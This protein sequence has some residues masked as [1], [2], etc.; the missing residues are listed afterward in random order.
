[1]ALEGWNWRGEEHQNGHSED[2]T[3]GGVMAFTPAESKRLI[4]R[5][6]V[7]MTP[8]RRA[9]ENG[10]VIVAGGTTNAYVAE[11]ILGVPVPGSAL[12]PGEHWG[13]AAV[14]HRERPGERQALRARERRTC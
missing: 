14:Q 11:E 5:A 2:D 8:V 7:A 6:V 13:R 4:A 10:R 3:V 1:M 9:L 12:H